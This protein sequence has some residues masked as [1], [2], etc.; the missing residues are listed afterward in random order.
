MGPE[1]DKEFLM[2]LKKKDKERKKKNTGG[3]GKKNFMREVGGGHMPKLDQGEKPEE[4]QQQ[5]HSWGKVIP[6][7]LLWLI[8][9]KK[10]KKKVN[11]IQF[12]EACNTEYN[13]KRNTQK[14]VL[15]TSYGNDC[16]MKIRTFQLT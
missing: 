11:S 16:K 2:R 4:H 8:F 3:W 14:Q 9:L 6:G 1:I 10:K 12:V 5:N 15:K 7:G 13:K